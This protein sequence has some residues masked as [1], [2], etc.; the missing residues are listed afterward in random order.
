MTTARPSTVPAY[1]FERAARSPAAMGFYRRSADG[2]TGE[3]WAALQDSVRRL[4]AH[5]VRLGLS[6]GDRVVLMLPT[7]IEWELCHLATLAAGGV[8][9]GID[10][11]DAPD[12]I[13]HILDIT[14]PRALFVS[15]PAQARALQQRL[16]LPPLL[17][18]SR[19]ETTDGS[20]H[21][22]PA[23]LAATCAET[24]PWP[25]AGP[26]SLATIIFTSGSTGRPKGIAYTHAQ[27][28]LACEA[29]LDRFPD[30]AQGARL[31]CW[32]P[33][34]NLFQRI[35]NI[36]GMIRG[37][38]SYFVDN[39]AQIVERLPEIRPTLF[40]GVPRFFEKLHAG[41][42]DNIARRPAWV[43]HAAR[44]AWNIGMEYRRTERRGARPGLYLE[45]AYRLADGI[46]LARLRRLMGSAL[47]FMISGSAPMPTW[48]LE[49]FHGLGWLVLE[50]Y[51]T[52]ENVIPIAINAPQAY[53]FGSVGR[54]M[55]WNEVRIA[56]DGELLVRGPGVFQGYYGDSSGTAPLDDE[57]YLHTGD[58]ARQDADGFIWLEGRKSEIFKTSTGC[59]IPPTPIEE[60][61]KRLPYVEHA[62]VFGRGR[63]RPVALLCLSQA[64]PQGRPASALAETLAADVARV[65][66]GLAVRNRP[67]GL[68]ITR[69]PLTVAA[70]EL[71][72]NLK[73]RRSAIEARY[74]VALDALYADMASGT[75]ATADIVVREAP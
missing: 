51:G 56:A 34:S 74:Q 31:A 75:S 27:L 23:L 64:M 35:I 32:L 73:L 57:G 10:A 6:P 15:D 29:I 66:A 37:A 71:T 18:F 65:C 25:K 30:V 53:R 12:N 33:L 54:P 11:H 62:V 46:F 43:R 38:E 7:S 45:L 20:C 63:P 17:T 44:W 59:R 9:V 40:I 61:L 68:L 69:Q 2:W 52:S 21:S 1:F 49:K 67:A 16:V 28:C 8:V 36:C 41:I 14:H 3:T 19:R 58:F 50:A 5:L 4:A 24:A 13:Q 70:G 39:P 72:S 47:Q 26:T 48:L 22:L 42:E 55:P 60:S